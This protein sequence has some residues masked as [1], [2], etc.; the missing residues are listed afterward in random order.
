MKTTLMIATVL[1]AGASAV[2]AQEPPVAQPPAAAESVPG[3]TQS[4]S[5]TG[6][7]QS[8][9]VNGPTQSASITGPTQ[10][11]PASPE[12]VREV[13]MLEGIFVN[14]VN[15]G[16]S[17]L[18][19]Q[20]QMI[21]PGTVI[22]GSVMVSPAHA[23]GI[24]LDGYGVLFDVDLP[25][26]NM[27]VMWSRRQLAVLNLREQISEAR[28]VLAHAAS[29]ADQQRITAQID[30][31]TNTLYVLTGPPPGNTSSIASGVVAVSQ[32]GAQP[33]PGSVMAATTDA[34][35]APIDIT[36]TPDEM[37]SDAIKKALMDTMVNHSSALM[38]GDDEWLI[39]AARDNNGPSIPGAIDDRSGVVLR[40]KGS[41]LAAF[42]TN[43][44]TRDEVLKKVE[45]REWR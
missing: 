37:Y 30:M 43:K 6:P 14:A 8:A 45:I 31:L 5:I 33:A 18:T 39:V 21:D 36:R 23:R 11:S 22:P 27:S 24:A 9:S 20:M 35:A 41:D 10:P 15:Q 17:D 4:A 16:A 29:P 38:L 44:M 34:A 32:G 42:R 26:M 12:R 2:Y 40:I 28:R 1:A 7:T 25:L 13:R 19:Q 3:P